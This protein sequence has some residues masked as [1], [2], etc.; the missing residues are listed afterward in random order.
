M[1]AK[2]VNITPISLWFMILTT[3]VISCFCLT[4]GKLYLMNWGD[5]QSAPRVVIEYHDCPV[6]LVTIKNA[7]KV[8]INDF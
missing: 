1:I 8:V 2:L 5:G 7:P 6:F 3:I 4:G